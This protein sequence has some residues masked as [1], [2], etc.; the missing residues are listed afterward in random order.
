[1]HVCI[2]RECPFDFICY[3]S[4]VIF[5]IYYKKLF[6]ISKSKLYNFVLEFFKYF[7]IYKFFNVAPVYVFYY[8]SPHLTFRTCTL[9]FPKY[10][11]VSAYIFCFYFSPVLFFAP[12]NTF[13]ARTVNARVFSKKHCFCIRFRLY[14]VI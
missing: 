2:M 13:N 10:S 8:V 1:M 14:L 3:F 4:T 9:V 5:L 12:G 11:H 6:S 7:V